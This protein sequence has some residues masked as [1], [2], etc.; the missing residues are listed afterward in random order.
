MYC[1]CRPGSLAFGVLVRV[2]VESARFALSYQRPVRPSQESNPKDAGSLRHG[3][4]EEEEEEE[5]DENR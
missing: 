2:L 5:E 4:E 1:W 3:E